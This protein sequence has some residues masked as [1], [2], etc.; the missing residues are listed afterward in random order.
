MAVYERWRVLE[1]LR[2]IPVFTNGFSSY[3]T[4]RELNWGAV[5]HAARMFHARRLMGNSS[6]WNTY[7]CVSA[8]VRNGTQ[9]LECTWRQG[10]ELHSTALNGFSLFV[11]L[12]HQ[13]PQAQR[14]RMDKLM[15]ETIGSLCI[16]NRPVGSISSFGEICSSFIQP[17]IEWYRLV[18]YG[19]WNECISSWSVLPIG[20]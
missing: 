11:S 12:H 20:T 17:P 15:P 5:D 18:M 6:L 3:F 14:V 7:V 13:L 9:P 10:L 1:T 8:K 2:W 16:E 4:S 19:K